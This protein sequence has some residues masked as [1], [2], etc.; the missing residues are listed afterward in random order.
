MDPVED[1]VENLFRL[2]KT[3]L[4]LLR[5]DVDVHFFGRHFDEENGKRISPPLHEI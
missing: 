5:M 1:H 3:D 4:G 2:D